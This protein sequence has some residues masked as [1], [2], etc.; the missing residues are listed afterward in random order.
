VLNRFMRP[1][2]GSA[3]R[4]HTSSNGAVGPGRANRRERDALLST[5][6]EDARQACETTSLLGC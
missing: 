5:A 4:K 3:D 2:R 6:C 1:R